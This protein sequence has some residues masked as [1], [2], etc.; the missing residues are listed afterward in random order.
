MYKINLI[1]TGLVELAAEEAAALL[2]D[3]AQGKPDRAPRVQAERGGAFDEAVEPQRVPGKDPPR[4]CSTACALI[5][6]RQTSGRSTLGGPLNLGHA[7]LQ[8]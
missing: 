2:E 4:L 8:E 5:E 7:L 3:V 6:A 1:C